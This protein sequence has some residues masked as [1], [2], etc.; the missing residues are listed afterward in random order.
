[1]SGNSFSH[2]RGLVYLLNCAIEFCWLA[3]IALVPIVFLNTADMPLELPKSVAFPKIVLFRSLVFL[4]VVL[5]FLKH[6]LTEHSISLLDQIRKILSLI[7]SKN[8]VRDTGQYFRNDSFRLIGFFALL[9]FLS[10]SLST[11]FSHS[12]RIR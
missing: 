3:M 2:S 11:L 1:M 5:W 4:M 9:D 10:V 7:K 12:L 8:I 6:L